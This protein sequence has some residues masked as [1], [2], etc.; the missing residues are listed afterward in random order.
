MLFNSLEFLIFFPVVTF[1][2]FLL[3]HKYRWLH[4]LLASCVF[5]CSFIPIY[6][7]I[8]I[9]TIV[10]DYIA[11][12]LI[13]NSEGNRKRMFLVMSICANVGVLA[14]FKYYNFFID[15]FQGLFHLFH[16]TFPLP[17]LKIILPIGLSF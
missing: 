17:I 6:I 15:N 9:F 8:L 14:I 4:L 16:A 11:G 5:Y 12:L 10:I 13:E 7:F 1:L 3:P 2:Y